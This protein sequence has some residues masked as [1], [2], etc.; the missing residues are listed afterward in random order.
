[1]RTNRAFSSSPAS[2]RR[3]FTLIELLVVIAIIAILIGLLLP[4]V[5]KIREAAA[6]MSCSNN[7]KQ[8]GL[9]FH[10]YA[11]T[12][13][14]DFPPAY[15]F[16]TTPTPNA[17]AWGVYLLPYIEQDNLFRQYDLNTIFVSGNNATVIATPVKTF[18]CPSTPGSP[19]RTYHAFAPLAAAE[20]L[21]P[22]TAAASDYHVTTG[23]LLTLWNLVASG[24]A[25]PDRHGALSAN[26]STK[27]LDFTDG[28]SNTI[29]LAEIAGKN[30]RWALGQK[31]STGDQQGGG[32]GDP[33]SGE[34]WLVGSD[35]TGTVSPGSFLVGVTNS[36]P[37]GHDG[38]GLYSFH[39]GGA[40]VLL[41]D[42]SVHFLA[43]STAANVVCY[44][45]TKANGEVIP[46]G[47]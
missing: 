23:V 18:Q 42:G 12:N 45:V 26:S 40:Q 7:M 27:I 37:A 19:T 21:P 24:V 30:D 15:T 11:N 8:L 38:L 41:A 5:Q 20:G 35:A 22:F 29:L 25:Q 31:V 28:T 47:F 16:V 1:M 32:W 10:N 44:L 17:H 34:N 4:A 46:D 3:A 2:E 43:S 39:T 33:F 36:Q 6:R 13:G 9:A 14:N